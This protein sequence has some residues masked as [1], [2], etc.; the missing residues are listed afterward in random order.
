MG[1]TKRKAVVN[2]EQSQLDR[3][4]RL[5]DEGDYRTVS[6]FMREAV[7]EKLERIEQRRIAE[8]VERYCAA[9]HADEDSGLVGAQAF[10]SERPRQS[11]RARRASR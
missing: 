5:V 3:I 4:Q 10:D 11:K 2:A 9:G 7:D 1:A 6:E 8:A